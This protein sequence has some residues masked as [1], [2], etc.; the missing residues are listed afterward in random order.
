LNAQQVI[1]KK[2]AHVR[3]IVFI[4]VIRIHIPVK[5]STLRT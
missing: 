1:T 3:S 5:K 4:H 2:Y